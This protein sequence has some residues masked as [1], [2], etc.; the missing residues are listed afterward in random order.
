MT[1]PAC[2]RAPVHVL[3]AFR[4]SFVHVRAC[5][6]RKAPTDT[7]A[8]AHGEVL[9]NVRAHGETL[10]KAHAFTGS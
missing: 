7:R 1:A 9:M 3:L 10:I 6:H 2:T 8:G 4:H 5:A